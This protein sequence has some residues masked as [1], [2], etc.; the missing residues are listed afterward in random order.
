MLIS[1]FKGGQGKVVLVNEIF[2]CEKRFSV[3]CKLGGDC[4]GFLDECCFMRCLCRG[5]REC[6]SNLSEGKEVFS[7]IFISEPFILYVFGSP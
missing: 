4:G 3:V 1:D 5:C 6:R 2:D 7:L